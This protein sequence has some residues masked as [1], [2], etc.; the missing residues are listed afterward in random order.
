MKLQIDLK[1]LMKIIFKVDIQ[2]S[3]LKWY[4][5]TELTILIL[6]GEINYGEKNMS[7][8]WYVFRR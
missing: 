3:I 2:V 4:N 5:K 1:K 7:K 8:L 6:T